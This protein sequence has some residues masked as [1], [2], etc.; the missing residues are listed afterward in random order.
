MAEEQLVLV[1]LPVV[2]GLLPLEEPSPLLLGCSLAGA[3][4]GIAIVKHVREWR[5]AILKVL[6]Y[7]GLKATVL[8]ILWVKTDHFLSD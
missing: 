8:L 4:A 2:P 7:T 3:G 1:E 5:C 6:L